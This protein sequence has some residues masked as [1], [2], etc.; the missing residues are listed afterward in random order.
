MSTL[1]GESVHMVFKCSKTMSSVVK[2]DLRCWGVACTTCVCK[3]CIGGK[4][5]EV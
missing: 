5:W 2:D 3:Q 1:E 4:T